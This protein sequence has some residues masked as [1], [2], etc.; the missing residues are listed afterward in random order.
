MMLA[1]WH[2]KPSVIVERFIL[3]PIQLTDGAEKAVVGRAR[4]SDSTQ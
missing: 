3:I 4:R 2:E 1:K